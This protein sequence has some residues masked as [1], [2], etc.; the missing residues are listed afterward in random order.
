[1]QGNHAKGSVPPIDALV[2]KP[3]LSVSLD[4]L[5][6]PPTDWWCFVVNQGMT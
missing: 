3:Q 6:S 4:T 1:M 5:P 2:A